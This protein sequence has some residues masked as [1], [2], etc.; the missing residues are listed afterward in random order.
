MVTASDGLAHRLP[1]T[2]RRLDV[3]ETSLPAVL[4]ARAVITQ[5]PDAKFALAD[6]HGY[7]NAV[8]NHFAWTTALIMNDLT[9]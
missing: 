3:G 9:E 2:R 1:E 8:G 5:Q 4:W 7:G 6:T